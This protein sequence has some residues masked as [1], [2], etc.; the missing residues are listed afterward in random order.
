[1]PSISEGSPLS[2]LEALAAGRP[3][4]AARVG[5]IPDVVTHEADGLLFPALDVGAGAEQVCRLLADPTLARRLGS[6]GRER[7]RDLTWAATAGALAAA[8]G[9][10][11]LPQPSR[12]LASIHG[13]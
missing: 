10:L 13:H 9:D 8:L 11:A 5:G 12:R 6:A 7:A 1:M 2:L 3:A 4:V